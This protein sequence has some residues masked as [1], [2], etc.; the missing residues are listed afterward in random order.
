MDRIPR[1]AHFVFGFRPQLEPFHLL[2][3][4][5]IESCR[6][7]VRPEKIYLTYHY[8]PYGVFWDLIRPH[9][10]LRRNE[11]VAEVLSARYDGGRVPEEYAYAHHADFV[12]LD[13][14]I[15]H[16]GIYA[17][18][19]TIFLRPLP[20]VLYQKSFVIGREPDVPDE[21][22]GA[23]RPSLC[24]ALLMAA[25]QSPFARTWRRRMAAAMN[26]TWSNHSGFLAQSLS[27]VFPDQVHVEPV[28]SFFPV[29]CS[30]EGLS[31]LFGAGPVDLARSY[32]VHFWGHVWWCAEKTDFSPHHAGE[33]NLP[34]M[35]SSQ[36]P[37][38]AMARPF[39]PDIDVD[40]LER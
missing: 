18:I 35:R 28:E 24:N 32:S 40:D 39:L 11:L 14:L 34:Y 38:S 10:T 17:D 30:P 25:P 22:T 6:R 23:L 13:A 9:L 27:Q 29:P 2:H 16:G 26:G 37:F 7:V 36:S 21:I 4:L 20:D 31:A 5:A 15:E 1:V 33:M 19:D 3:Y 8:L 12:R